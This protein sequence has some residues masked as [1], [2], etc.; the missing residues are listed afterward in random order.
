MAKQYPSTFRHK[1]GTET[2]PAAQKLTNG[3]GDK[4]GGVTKADGRARTRAATDEQRMSPWFETDTTGRTV[5]W[6]AGQ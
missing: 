4:G 5:N 2:H 6:R 1:E 3:V